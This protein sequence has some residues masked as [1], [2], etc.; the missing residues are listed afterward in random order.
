MSLITH[1]S[2]FDDHYG[3]DA[4]GFLRGYIIIGKVQ[5]PMLN[6]DFPSMI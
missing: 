6:I 1:K 2:Q 5:E 4:A 3:L